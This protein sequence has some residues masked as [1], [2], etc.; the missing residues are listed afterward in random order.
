MFQPLGRVLNN[1]R[2]HVPVDRDAGDQPS[3]KTVLRGNAI[4]MNLILGIRRCVN[5]ADAM[6]R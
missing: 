6:E 3:A 5:G 4:V 2:S 1:W